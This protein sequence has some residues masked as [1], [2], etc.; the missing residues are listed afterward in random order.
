MAYDDAKKKQIRVTMSW[1]THAKIR[2]W[3]KTAGTDEVSGFG[4]VVRLDGHLHVR[5]AF[6]IKQENTGGSTDID[7]EDMARTMYRTKDEPGDLN[8]WWHSHHNMA[9]YFSGT[10]DDTIKQFG[11]NGW[12]LATVFNHRDEHKTSLFV[13]E[14][15]NIL[16]EDLKL[17][18]LQP[19]LPEQLV[20][21]CDASYK[22]K[23]S[24]KKWVPVPKTPWQSKAERKAA[25]RAAKQLL[26]VSGAVETIEDEEDD[27][28]YPTYPNYRPMSRYIAEK[29][30]WEVWDDRQLEW[31]IE[32]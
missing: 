29:G 32:S 12:I 1:L 4:K 31:V 3:M 26:L 8:F 17:E 18:I 5:D 7:P 11:K 10:D 27:D 9:A 22:E 16:I 13:N 2:H 15:T 25:K 21:S 14:P 6:L 19:A 20:A 23:V 24:V 30:Y 28:D